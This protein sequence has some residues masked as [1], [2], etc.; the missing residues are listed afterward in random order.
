ML[1]VASGRGGRVSEEDA[2]QEALQLGV[3]QAYKSTYRLFS[4]RDIH[5]RSKC[6][7]GLA[8]YQIIRMHYS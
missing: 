6:R 8:P 5:E 7:S 1:S 4:K 2:V 3:G